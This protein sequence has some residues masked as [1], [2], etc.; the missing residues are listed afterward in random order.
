MSARVLILDD[1]ADN[2]TSSTPS[3]RCRSTLIHGL[4][5]ILAD[6]D[7]GQ[8]DQLEERLR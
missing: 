3:K 2:V 8:Q 4:L 1:D 5:Q 7:Y 6:D